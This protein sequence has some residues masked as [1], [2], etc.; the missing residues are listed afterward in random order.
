MSAELVA[1]TTVDSLLPGSVGDV[2]LLLDPFG[3]FFLWERRG[4]ILGVWSPKDNHVHGVVL[5]KSR[6]RRGAEGC[7]LGKGLT[8]LWLRLRHA[9]R[10]SQVGSAGDWASARSG[11]RAH[12]EEC[13]WGVELE[14]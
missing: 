7:D 12:E 3:G 1:A 14:S 8:E 5:A 6:G 4:R 11:G 13:A 9:D 2:R 10:G